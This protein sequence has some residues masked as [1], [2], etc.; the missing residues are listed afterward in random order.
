MEESFKMNDKILSVIPYWFLIIIISGH[1]YRKEKNLSKELIWASLRNGIQ[2]ILLAFLLEIIF[3]SSAM[4]VTV[5]IALVMTLNSSY[6]IVSR[7]KTQ[8]YNLFSITFFSHI[9][10]LWPIAFLFSFDESKE[11]WSEPRMLLPLLGMILGS[12]LSGVSIAL[13]SFSQSFKEK[14]GEI[15]T[16]LSLG[17][18]S[19]EATRKFFFRALRAGMTPQIN[20][21]LAMG[22]ISIPG[23]M[24]GQIISNASAFEAAVVQMKMMICISAGTVF[25]TYISLHFLRKKLFL[26]TGEICLE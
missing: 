16:K 8:K 18:S 10:S 13:G 12:T 3:K 24:A 22:I 17:A 26:P 19:E 15:I 5:A 20:S 4:V 6:H 7:S 14:R 1:L 2:L 11:A 9:F 21:M 23:M 25:C